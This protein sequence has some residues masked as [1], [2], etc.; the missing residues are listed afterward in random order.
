MINLRVRRVTE[1]PVKLHQRYVDET[2]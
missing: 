2:R 1:P